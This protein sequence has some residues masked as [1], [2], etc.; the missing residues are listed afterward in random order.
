ML[1][2]IIQY[3][4][5]GLCKTTVT[6]YCV[7]LYNKT[8]LYFKKICINVVVSLRSENNMFVRIHL[9]WHVQTVSRST[10]MCVIKAVSSSCVISAP[11]AVFV[12]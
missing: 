12:V 4:S 3:F 9:H 10:G 5:F 7:I 1:Q 2:I 8:E 6:C 11:L